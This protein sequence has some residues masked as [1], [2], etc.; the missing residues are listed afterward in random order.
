MGRHEETWLPQ[1]ELDEIDVGTVLQSLAD[2]MRL[3][4]VRLLDEVGESTC[5]ALDLPVKISTVS[6][7]MNQLRHNGLV[8]TR[9]LGA[10]RPS[11]LRRADLERRF[12]GLLDAIIKAA[13]PRPAATHQAEPDPPPRGAAAAPH[14][15]A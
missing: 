2:P 5:T 12:P 8:S 9:L 10:S 13:P 15:V 6:H 7:H 11:R 14:G 1:P 3:R 4:I